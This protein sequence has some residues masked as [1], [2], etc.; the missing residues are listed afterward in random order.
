MW[1][2]MEKILAVVLHEAHNQQI[3]ETMAA[4]AEGVDSFY[5]KVLNPPPQE[6]K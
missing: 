3:E 4:L 6:E 5:G 1:V 2:R